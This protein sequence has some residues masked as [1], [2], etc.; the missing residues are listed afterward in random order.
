MHL[1]AQLPKASQPPSAGAAERRKTLRWNCGAFP[2]IVWHVGSPGIG[3]LV[4]GGG[5]CR[6]SCTCSG[7][8]DMPAH[9]M[10]ADSRHAPYGIHTHGLRPS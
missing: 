9:I 4:A 6:R 8:S 5:S 10:L 2:L 3:V 1:A 7:S